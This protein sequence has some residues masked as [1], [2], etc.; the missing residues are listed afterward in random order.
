MVGGKFSTRWN[1]ICPP[2]SESPLSRQLVAA[3][4]RGGAAL[5]VT[6]NLKDFPLKALEKYDI[7]ATHPDDFLQERHDYTRLMLTFDCFY[8][9]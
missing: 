4:V 9:T 3:A 5:I 2:R 1:E 6:A 8:R 7:E